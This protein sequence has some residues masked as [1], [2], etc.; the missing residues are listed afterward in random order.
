MKDDYC[1][2]GESSG[3][4]RCAFGTN[5][6]ALML[7]VYEGCAVGRYLLQVLLILFYILC[8]IQHDGACLK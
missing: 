5:A 8:N 7:C 3:T 4:R 2:W 6:E 1:F